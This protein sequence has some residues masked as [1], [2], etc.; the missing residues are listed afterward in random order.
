MY[1]LDKVCYNVE[2]GEITMKTTEEKILEHIN[3]VIELLQEKGVST[4]PTNPENMENYFSVFN[5]PSHLTISG[6]HEEIR[7]EREV[8]Q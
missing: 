4:I 2:K 7:I 3:K 1:I 8:K 6:H 5:Y